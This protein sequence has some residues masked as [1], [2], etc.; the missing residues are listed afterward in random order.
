[1]KPYGL[2]R[3]L[4]FNS[5]DKEDC[6]E[7]GVSSKFMKLKSKVRKKAR[8]IWKGKERGKVRRELAG[9]IL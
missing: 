2:S 9:E 3:I 6:L 5:F 8:R 1:M 7:R 4:F